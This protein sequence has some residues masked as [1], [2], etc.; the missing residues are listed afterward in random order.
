MNK[1]TWQ[2]IVAGNVSFWQTSTK[3]ESMPKLTSM[4]ARTAAALLASGAL[5]AAGM[6]TAGAAPVEAQPVAHGGPHITSSVADSDVNYTIT[7][8]PTF[9]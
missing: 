7:E 2:I 9:A 5:V 6:Q 1:L 4:L 3:E 8:V